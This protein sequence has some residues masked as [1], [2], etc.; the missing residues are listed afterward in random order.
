ML[1]YLYEMYKTNFKNK[2]MF[3][4]GKKINNEQNYKNYI[5]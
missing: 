4:C 2:A 3:L 5:I 1:G